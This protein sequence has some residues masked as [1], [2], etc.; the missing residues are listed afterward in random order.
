MPTAYGSIG[1][2]AGGRAATSSNSSIIGKG[3]WAT[4]S[5]NVKTIEGVT[6]VKSINGLQ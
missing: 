1:K 6:A 5:G 3:A 4:P 2:R